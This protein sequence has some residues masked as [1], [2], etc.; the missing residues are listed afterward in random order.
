L[1]GHA[2]YQQSWAARKRLGELYDRYDWRNK[3]KGGGKL[4]DC[5]T[6]LGDSF[7]ERLPFSVPPMVRS[8][9][10]VFMVCM[11]VGVSSADEKPKDDNAIQGEWRIVSFV[12]DG[13][14]VPAAEFK[15]AYYAFEKG[16]MVMKKDGKMFVKGTYTLDPSK[17]PK[18]ID[19]VVTN[20]KKGE[21]E[22]GIYKLEGDKLTICAP[23]FAKNK[24]RPKEFASKSKSGTILVVLERVKK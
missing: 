19:V 2:V 8:L 23:A 15:G 3:V 4:S 17:T 22:Q 20:D 11:A 12:E 1:I 21:T 24:E 13:Q 10:Q 14:G 16:K 9:S 6:F 18:H 7:Q 5:I